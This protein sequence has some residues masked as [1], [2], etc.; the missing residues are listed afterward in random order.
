M[1]YTISPMT[2]HTGAGGRVSRSGAVDPCCTSAGGCDADSHGRGGACA[3]NVVLLGDLR[4]LGG[5]NLR[6]DFVFRHAHADNE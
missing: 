3:R 2:D 1:E 4:C 6:L 5:L